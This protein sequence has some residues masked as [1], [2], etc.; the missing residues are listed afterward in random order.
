MLKGLELKR[1]IETILVGANQAKG[2]EE[3]WRNYGLWSATKIDNVR[4]L[5]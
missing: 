1:D 5:F 4:G 2:D 3:S